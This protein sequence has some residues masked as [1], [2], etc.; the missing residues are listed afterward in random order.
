[1][2]KITVIGNLTKKDIKIHKAKNGKEY[3]TFIL[4]DNPFKKTRESKVTG[5]MVAY[6]VICWNE[7]AELVKKEAMPGRQFKV[8]GNLVPRVWTKDGITY[9]GMEIKASEI[10]AGRI[11]NALRKVEEAA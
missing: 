8:T 6:K 4:C 2:A 1:M 11:P 7:F 10:V 5:E 9:E 3:V